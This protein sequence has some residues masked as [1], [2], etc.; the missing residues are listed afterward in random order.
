MASLRAEVSALDKDVPLANVKSM[1]QYVIPLKGQADIL[2]CPV[3]EISPYNVNSIMNPILVHC[4]GL[5][6]LFNMYRNK[7][8][9]RPGGA[10]ILVQQQAG[11]RTRSH[12]GPYSDT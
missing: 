4:L 3:P 9:V 6:Y 7:P 1:E 12:R 2:I 5:G 11:C 10:A 8:L